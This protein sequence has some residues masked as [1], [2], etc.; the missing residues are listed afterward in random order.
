MS[1]STHN[2]YSHFKW[3]LCSMNAE[4]S[5][6][7]LNQFICQCEIECTNG[8]QQKA[9]QFSL[10]SKSASAMMS[11]LDAIEKELREADK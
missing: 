11:K 1:L 5:G 2:D 7:A 3:E 9:T 4:K 8:S 6:K 10:D